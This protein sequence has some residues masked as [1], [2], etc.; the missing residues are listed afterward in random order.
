MLDTLRGMWF[1]VELKK[2]CLSIRRMLDRLLRKGDCRILM[3]KRGR[4]GEA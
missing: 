3:T 2:C 4:T 1:P